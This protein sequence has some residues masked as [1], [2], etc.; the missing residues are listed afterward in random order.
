ME[1]F[2]Q[3]ATGVEEIDNQHKELIDRVNRVLAA[4]TRQEG[5]EAVKEALESM[6]SYA[7][8]LF[9]IEERI[10]RKNEYPNYTAHRD[11]HDEFVCMLQELFAYF[12]EEG[13]SSHVVMMVNE[14]L[15]NWLIQ[16]FLSLDKDALEYV[17]NAYT[18]EC[19]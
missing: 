19:L 8:E 14:T 10:Q 16:H 6:G 13:P 12:D 2:E 18:V 15:T 3:L 5:R 1:W 17:R 7:I 9:R 4:C 11:A